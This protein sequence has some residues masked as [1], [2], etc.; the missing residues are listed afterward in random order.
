M[1]DDVLVALTLEGAADG[2][3]IC[4]RFRIEER[5]ETGNSAR[6]TNQQPLW[7]L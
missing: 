2:A 6:Y 1:L 5:E 3:V 7:W 4:E